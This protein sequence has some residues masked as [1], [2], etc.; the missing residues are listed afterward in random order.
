M[1]GSHFFA[2]NGAEIGTFEGNLAVSSAGS[3]EDRKSRMCTFDFGH[4]GHGFWVQG[5]GVS[6]DRNFAFGH[7]GSAF[8]VFSRLIEEPA[9]VPW[10]DARNLPERFAKASS[11]EPRLG[12]NKVPF[13]AS[14]NVAAASEFG[15]QIRYHKRNPSKT[16]HR[17]CSILD[18]S[19]FWA[20]REEALAVDYSHHVKVRNVAIF[21]GEADDLRG[22]RTNTESTELVF[23][24][25]EVR[26][27][28]DGIRVPY[29]GT[30][31]ITGG[32]F[33]NQR[34]F[35]IY[36]P[37]SWGRR[38]IISGTERLDAEGPWRNRYH[39]ALYRKPKRTGVG[40]RYLYNHNLFF[41]D[42]IELDGG[43]VYSFDQD[44]DAVPIREGGPGQLIGLT[45]GE[46]RKRY[47]LAVGGSLAGPDAAK[48]EQIWGLVGKPS[49]VVAQV[50]PLFAE[51]AS[52]AFRLKGYRL[53]DGRVGD[54]D[55]TGYAEGWRLVQVEPTPNPQYLLAYV[56]RTA[57]TLQLDPGFP[58]AICPQDLERGMLI[59]GRLQ[60]LIGGFTSDAKFL[61]F[62]INTTVSTRRTLLTSS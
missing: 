50:E 8:I 28:R 53:P 47:G 49:T 39:V 21:G 30:T 5:G 58:R 40:A 7:A 51:S 1:A 43:Q 56:D 13:S 42:T 29:F 23:E 60:D 54:V 41:A 36:T 2:E 57:P 24:D 61:G 18:D 34:N 46:I 37:I 19:V 35:V 32:R 62:C 38:V 52:N 11:W 59:G 48:R 14:S 15:F 44:P 3:G 16:R 45:S 4:G 6:L 17:V 12:S 9:G 31:E 26:R 22:V 20:T 25:L 27:F 55:L 10:F 33:A